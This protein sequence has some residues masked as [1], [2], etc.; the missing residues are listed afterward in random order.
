MKRIHDHLTDFRLNSWEVALLNIQTKKKKKCSLGLTFI[1]LCFQ[2]WAVKERHTPNNLKQPFGRTGR[3]GQRCPHSDF[4]QP[5][6]CWQ[7]QGLHVY[8][9]VWAEASSWEAMR[10][11]S[12]FEI[13]VKVIGIICS[14]CRE[15]D[16]YGD[17]LELHFACFFCKERG[18]C[19]YFT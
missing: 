3:A 15:A 16:V 14:S 4:I 17:T 1:P 7:V 8:Q 2:G 11:R 19:K 10:Q 18:W 9:T 13:C 6:H 5:E 12:S